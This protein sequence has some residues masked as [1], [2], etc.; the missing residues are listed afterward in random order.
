MKHVAALVVSLVALVLPFAVPA[1]A[2]A[3]VNDFTVTDFTADY[4]LTKADPQGQMDVAEKINVDFTDNN[5]GI[6][7]AIPKTY[8]NQPLHIQ[9]D[10]VTSDSGAP[11]QYTTYDDNNGNELLKIGDPNRTVT[12]AQEYTIDYTMQN[13]ITF[14]GDH[15]ELYWD[16]NGDQWNQ[17]FT[18]VR[19]VLHIPEGLQLAR[20]T[21]C[22]TGPL[23]TIDDKNCTVEQSPTVVQ[24]SASNLDA[25]F[26]LTFVAGFNKGYFAPP[27]WQDF[28]SD[29]MAQFA[30]FAVPFVLIGGAGFIWWL[31]RGRDAKGTGVIIP[32][33]DAPDN[34][35]PLECGTL[36]DFSVDNRDL[37]ATIIDLAI[38]KYLRI[39]EAE[40]KQLFALNEKGFRLELLNADWSEL[41]AWEKLLMGGIFGASGQSTPVALA[42][43][44]TMLRPVA[45]DIKNSVEESMAD[46]GYFNSDPT[47]YLKISVG[48]IIASVLLFLFYSP[49]SRQEPAVWGIIAGG[50]V[51]GV[52]YHFLAARTAKGVAANEHLL[53]LKMYL[54]VAEKDRI[55][56]MQSPDGRYAAWANAP[57]Q[58]IE[59]FEK[60]L[61]YAIVLQVEKEWAKKFDNLYAAPPDWYTGSYT[62]FNAGYLVGSLSGGFNSAMATSFALSSSSGGSGFGGGGFAGGGGGGGGGGGW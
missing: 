6:L 46:R 22:Y 32:Q 13:V 31:L 11:S 58:T 47:K 17:P 16:V 60:L 50:M 33:Y 49:V 35:S 53:G 26:T 14:Y 24:A 18:R 21:Q 3:G 1:V 25:G 20:T 52:F 10:K 42:A 8:K 61:P 30:E 23:G 62:A 9:V 39:V 43:L 27:T 57:G 36:I 51:F 5:H 7:R 28:A 44:A 45:K 56:M 40:D 41:N 34:L 15:D 37:T 19:A 48:T 54:N 59:L 4:Y 38:R 12:G 29:H 2:Y 55:K